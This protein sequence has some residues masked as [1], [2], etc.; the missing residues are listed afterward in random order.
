VSPT[1]RPR[2]VRVGPAWADDGE[3][4]CARLGEALGD[5]LAGGHLLDVVHVGSTAVPGL[6]AEPT[7]DL[8]ARVH[9]CPLP[10]EAGARLAALG[11]VHRGE[12]GPSGGSYTTRGPHEIHLRVVGRDDDTWHR[13]VALRDHLRA[14]GAAR[15]RHEAA[16]HAGLARAEAVPDDRSARAA[17]QDAKR[18]VIAA[19][20]AEALGH[21]LAHTGFG[22]VVELARGLADAPARWAVHG[23][24]A[25]D[26]AAG[27]PSRHH[28]DVDV[29]VDA[30]GAA[31]LLDALADRG[32]RV[33]WVIAGEPAAY[34]PRRAGEAHPG[35]G[36]QAHA[37][38]GHRWIDV[39]L[40]PWAPDAWRYRRDPRVTLPLDRALRRVAVAGVTVPVLAPEVVLLFKATAGGRSTPRPKDDADLARALPSLDA[41]ARAWLRAGLP[42]GHP[43]RGRLA[44][45]TT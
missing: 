17:Y 3:R 24:W 43:W 18:D 1:H 12:H 25:L 10:A 34:L 37:R 39:V 33:A 40:E 22:P 11:F 20:E 14:S 31:A 26:L 15:A 9:P 19:L 6:L 35:G 27:A 16:E 23:G 13:L 45:A 38:W 5:A 30:A 41:A 2:L 36:H 8:L 42:A 28:E 7:L 29:A 44:D 32:A 21:A 4:W